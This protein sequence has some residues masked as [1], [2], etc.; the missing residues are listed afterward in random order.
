MDLYLESHCTTTGDRLSNNILYTWVTGVSLRNHKS[1]S[2]A[3]AGV[4]IIHVYIVR[5]PRSVRNG[6]DPEDITS[7]ASALFIMKK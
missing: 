4:F 6:F 7:T 2:R 5:K 1:F 3:D